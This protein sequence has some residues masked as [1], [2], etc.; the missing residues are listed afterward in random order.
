MRKIGIT[1]TLFLLAAVGGGVYL[2][3]HSWPDV[4]RYMR[5]REM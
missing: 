4:K 2:A 3:I 5:M 1:T